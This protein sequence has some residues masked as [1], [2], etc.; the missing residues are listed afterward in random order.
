MTKLHKNE[1][2]PEMACWSLRRGK[3]V[4]RVR[5]VGRHECQKENST[6][7]HDHNIVTS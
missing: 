3:S 5:A 1:A 2:K 4:G 7:K 6:Q